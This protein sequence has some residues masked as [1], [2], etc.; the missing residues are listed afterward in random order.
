MDIRN[1]F[2][3]N[4]SYTP[5]PLALLIIYFAHPSWPLSVWGLVVV[6]LGEMTRASGVRYAGGITR[7]TKVGAPSLCTSGPFARVRNPLY[8]GNMIMYTGIVLF[9]GSSNLLVML[10]ITWA[11]FILQYGLIISLEEQKLTELF[12]DAYETYKANVPALLPRLRPWPNTDD[13]TPMSIAK[14]VRTE[15]RTLQNVAVIAVII[16]LR[17]FLF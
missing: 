16:L 3:K 11:F 15:R 12:G 8:L 13:R 4:R 9:A 2:F 14:T 10:L 17:A 5:V 1:F 6:L 7:T